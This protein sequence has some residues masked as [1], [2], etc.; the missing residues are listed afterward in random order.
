MARARWKYT[1]FSAI[2]VD[3]CFTRV[4]LKRD[5]NY[6]VCVERWY[7]INNFNFTAAL[8]THNGQRFVTRQF[9]GAL[10]GAQA[11]TL[12]KTKKPVFYYTKKKK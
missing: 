9:S 1:T 2:D 6:R 4:A 10:I 8:T 11:G 5:I 3:I 12:V 7:P